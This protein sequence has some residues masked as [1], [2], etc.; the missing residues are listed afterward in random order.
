MPDES[1][2][3]GF[4]DEKPNGL[5]GPAPATGILPAEMVARLGGLESRMSRAED[6]IPAA[7][8]LAQTVTVLTQHVQ[9][10]EQQRAL[11]ELQFDRW[12]RERA[13][14]LAIEA[15]PDALKGTDQAS[16]QIIGYAGA[17][18]GWLKSGAQ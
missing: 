6:H 15:L 3:V 16:E 7:M 5:A 11:A 13:L 14:A 10:L 12:A 18:L 4:D 9:A 8:Q 1:T 2:F 17:F